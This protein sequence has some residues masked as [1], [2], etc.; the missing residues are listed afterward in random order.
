MRKI[1]ISGFLLIACLAQA[2]VLSWRVDVDPNNG[3]YTT[4][5]LFAT[6]GSANV[7]GATAQSGQV[8]K[9]VN[10]AYGVL[11]TDTILTVGN[12]YSFFVA[13]FDSDGVTV[14]AYSDLKSWGTLVSESSLWTGSFPV[15]PGTTYWNAVPEPTSMGLLAIG[16]SALLLRRRR[17]T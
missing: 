2:E 7:I 3:F 6:T 17:R 4:A 13:L 9:Y 16:V 10:E 1:L 14:K 5:Q 11:G 15:P 12:T 8:G